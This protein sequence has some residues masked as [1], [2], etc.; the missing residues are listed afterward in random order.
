MPASSVTC[1]RRWIT[2]L[3]QLCKL[4]F[5]FYRN[6]KDFSSFKTSDHLLTGRQKWSALSNVLRD[7]ITNLKAVQ[8]PMPVL[9]LN[10]KQQSI[11]VNYSTFCLIWLNNTDIVSIKCCKMLFVL[12]G[13]VVT[14]LK[15]GGKL[16]ELI[17]IIYSGSCYHNLLKST[18]F[19]PRYSEVK[20]C[21]F[22]SFW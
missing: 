19:W 11:T 15:W 6:I 4:L 8:N 16:A 17:C 13:S 1:W 2:I 10:T 7:I 3:W 5:T 22:N 14:L 18:D 12:Q 9:H 21:T 20:L